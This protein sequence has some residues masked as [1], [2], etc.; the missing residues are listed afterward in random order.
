MA[1][2]PPQ[3]RR[4]QMELLAAIVALVIAY[5]GYAGFSMVGLTGYKPLGMHRDSL[6]AE[7]DSITAQVTRAKRDVAGGALEK[8]D[9]RLAEFGASLQL[10]RQLV[11]AR[12]D[13]PNLLDDITSRAKMRGTVFAGVVPQAVESGTPYD[14]QRYRLTVSGQYDAIAEFLTDIASLPRIIVPYDIHLA[15]VQGPAADTTQSAA[16]LQATLAIRTF[17]KQMP[18]TTAEAA[19]ARP[20]AAKK[21]GDD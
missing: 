16:Q 18:D 2:F 10:M 13:V 15:R 1:A 11:P 14:V 21:G 7:I 6:Q 20:A 9:Q 12:S 4:S 17:V 3:D 19:S 5:F 8:L